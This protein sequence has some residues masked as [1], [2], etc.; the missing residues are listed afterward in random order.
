MADNKGGSDLDVF[1]GLAKKP[2]RPT[3]P[4]M[5]P[6]PP[7]APPPRGKTLLGGLSGPGAP[8][9][10]P[11]TGGAPL[12]PP[13]LPKPPGSLGPLPPVAPPPSKVGAA[14][15]PP[16][17][18]P[19]PPL[20]PPPG[21]SAESRAP[22]PLPPPVPPPAASL[23]S[24]LGLSP[25]KKGGAGGAAVDMDWDDEEESTH[26]YDKATDGMP[27]PAPP[28]PR[29]AAGLPAVSKASAAASLLAASG[30]AAKPSVQ[31]PTV[32]P[33]PPLPTIPQ[34]VAPQ[35][36][37]PA[38]PA[39]RLD[40]PTAIR[41]RPVVPQQQGGSKAGIVLGGLALVVVLAL[42]AFML[43]PRKGELNIDVKSKTGGPVAKAEIFINGQKKCDTA[44]C[45]VKDLEA[46]SV[47]IKVL[48]DFAP[49]EQTGMV[50]AGKE[51]AVL[52][53]VEVGKPANEPATASGP[54]ASQ[55]G[56]KIAGA[57]EGAKVF[58]DGAEKGTLPIDL[59]DL[60]PGT[61][62][63]RIEAG[64]RYEKVERSVE[65]AGGE[66]K[67]LGTIKLK[68]LKGQVVLELGTAGANVAIVPD[69]SKKIEISDKQWKSQPVKIELDPGEGYKLIATK[70]GFDDFKQ[71]IS[72]DDGQAVKTIKIDMT[73]TGKEPPSTNIPGPGPGPGPGRSGPRPR[74]DNAANIHRNHAAHFHGRGRRR[75][76][77]EHQFHSRF[78]SCARRPSARQHAQS[79]RERVVRLAHRDVHSS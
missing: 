50:E 1:E 42:A 71:E 49:A 9:P 33:A 32:P 40:E 78:Q 51:K 70:K 20:P 22:A 29:P 24:Q 56:L 25:K 15:P 8:P 47:S 53:Q 61:H 44:P 69:K 48:G 12:P 14:L 57:T 74:T 19:P 21:L 60:A 36:P 66:T 34:S 10:P 65:I 30:G 75:L 72:F 31:P 67:D 38:Q 3:T 62:K 77:R 13:S 11:P 79:R 76:H 39:S 37:V 2:A 4:G 28:Q 17:A 46:G 18:P 52:I 6:P 64:D 45:L 55:A 16:S 59:K 54:S 68:V 58:I 26:V 41:P 23:G 35:P 73:E 27:M 7:A 5:A 43:V 63:V